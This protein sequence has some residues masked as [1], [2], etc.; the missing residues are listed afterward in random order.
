MA[1]TIRSLHCTVHPS[2]WEGSQRKDRL[3]GRLVNTKLRLLGPLC[4]LLHERAVCHSVSVSGL[5]TSISKL[6]PRD[7]REN[8]CT[9][10]SFFFLALQNPSRSFFLSKPRNAEAN[11]PID[12]L[13]VT[14]CVWIARK[15][16]LGGRNPECPPVLP[17]IV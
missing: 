6:C 8:P 13:P 4:W 7:I 11:L 17:Y 5:Q 14:T 3:G 9:L 2:L 10:Q 1:C 12:L 15:K 16:T